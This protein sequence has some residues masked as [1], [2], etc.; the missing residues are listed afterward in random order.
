MVH[1]S[2]DITR[3]GLAG[4]KA[5]DH[6]YETYQEGIYSPE[7][8]L[9]T[10]ETMYGQAREE[11]AKGKPVVLDAS[12]KE[13]SE[14]ERA[15]RIAHELEAEFFVIECTALESEIQRRLNRR[16]QV[17]EETLSDARWEIYSQQ[18]ADWQP[19]KEV[20]EDHY[21]QL[22]TT[23]SRQDTIRTLLQRV[24]ARLLSS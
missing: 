21:I 2:S 12:F 16:T 10:Y 18:K 9:L 1:I 17:G 23:G 4:I 19:I 22:D 24:F 6:R 14:R 3:K 8:T 11:L 20:S 13:R 5:L 15:V 7:F